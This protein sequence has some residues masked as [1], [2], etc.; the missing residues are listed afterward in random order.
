MMNGAALY[1]SG[2]IVP[3]YAQES[4][5][6]SSDTDM[7]TF[8]GVTTRRNHTSEKETEDSNIVAPI[9]LL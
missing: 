5:L 1:N 9:K 3:S 4:A 2:L 7:P 6:S 8:M